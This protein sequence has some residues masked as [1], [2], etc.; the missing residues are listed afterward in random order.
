LRKL[1]DAASVVQLALAKK[2][3]EFNKDVKTLGD[4][5][6]AETE[7]FLLRDSLLYMA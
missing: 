1:V 3:Q 7:M 4:L 6:A 2:A 5:G